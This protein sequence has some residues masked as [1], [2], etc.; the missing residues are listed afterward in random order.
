[1]KK[2]QLKET[3]RPIVKECINVILLEEGMLSTII[4][5]VVKGTSVSEPIVEQKRNAAPMNMKNRVITSD[6]QLK[7]LEQRKKMMDAIGKDAYNGVNIFEGTEALSRGG[8]PSNSTVANG[9][10]AGQDPRDPGVDISTF[11]A[12]SGIWKKVMDK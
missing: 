6:K 12:S 4:S 10:L 8:N 3:L 1:M 5:E 11:M 2:S 9:P 7:A